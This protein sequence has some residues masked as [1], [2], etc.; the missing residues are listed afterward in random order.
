MIG[1]I[2]KMTHFACADGPQGITEQM[3]VFNSVTH[4]MTG[5]VSV[6][7]SAATLRFADVYKRQGEFKDL[8]PVGK[9]GGPY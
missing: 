2:G 6:C 7:N 9:A 1:S 8:K 5:P 3:A 4:K